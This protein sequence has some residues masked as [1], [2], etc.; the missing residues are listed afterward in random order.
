MALLTAARPASGDAVLELAC[1]P[2]GMIPVLA[3]AVSPGGKVIA[4]DI[5]PAMVEAAA[6]RVEDARLRGVDVRVLDLDWLDLETAS[7]GAL[8]CRFGYMFAGD[9]NSALMEARRVIRPGGR[10]ATAVWDSPDVNPYGRIPL[11][12]LALIGLGDVP[13][14]GTPGMFALA[15]G[16]RLVDEILGAGFLEADVTPVPVRFRFS[17]LDDLV[18][19]VLALSQSVNE[20]IAG[21]HPDSAEAW[22][23]ALG[24]LTADFGDREGSIILPGQALVLSATA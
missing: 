24:D 15:D 7:F 6:L 5:S 10:I 1:G 2:G 20:A 18:G 9:L 3:E 17:S 11:E 14:A 19:W 22:R 13:A 12:A 16:E 23:A 4:G 21:G 8:V